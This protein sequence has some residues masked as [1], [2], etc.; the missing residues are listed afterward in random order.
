MSCPAGF[1]AGLSSSCRVEC[2]ASYK[3]INDGGNERCVSAASN[4]YYVK[5]QQ[6]PK[7]ASASAFSDEQAR[8]LAE[9]ITVTKKVQADLAAATAKK[10]QTVAPRDT[11]ESSNEVAGMYAEA[12]AALR[13]FRPPTQPK[14]D[15]M[16]AKLSIKNIL[17][18]DVRTIQI[19]LFFV[20]IALLEY[21][22][23]PASVVHGIAFFTLCVGFSIAIYLSNI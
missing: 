13:P 23:L 19:C 22:L 3:Y 21:L 11:S 7:G 8:F 4:K 9:F 15:I 2:P 5:L 20:V 1:E 12:N 16:N 6:V 10:S 17:A 18:K 14:E